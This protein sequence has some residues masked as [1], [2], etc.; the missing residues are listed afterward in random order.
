[1]VGFKKTFLI[2]L[3]GLRRYYSAIYRLDAERIQGLERIAALEQT[4]IAL[5]NAAAKANAPTQAM[6]LANYRLRSEL[7]RAIA[8]CAEERNKRLGLHSGG[9]DEA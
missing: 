8:A 5:Q 2:K 6:E 9:V 7:D 1:V 4:I 3:P